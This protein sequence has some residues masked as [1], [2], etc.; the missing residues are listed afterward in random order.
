MQFLVESG[1]ACVVLAIMGVPTLSGRRRRA[2]RAAAGG[3]W[4]VGAAGLRIA[5][6]AIVRRGDFWIVLGRH[7]GNDPTLAWGQAL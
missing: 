5:K 4:V 3:L 2:L 6:L 7:G 1:G